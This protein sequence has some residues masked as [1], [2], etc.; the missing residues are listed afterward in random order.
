MASPVQIPDLPS[1]PGAVADS[2]LT[3][4]RSGLTDYKATVGLIRA[5]SLATYANLPG[6][7]QNTDNMLIVRGSSQYR[8]PFSRV[9]FVPGL[10]LWFYNTS[11]QIASSAPGWS[12]VPNTGDA[13][14][15]CAGG[16]TYNTAQAQGGSWTLPSITL[17]I[18]NIPQHQH[19]L[20]AQRQNQGGVPGNSLESLMAGTSTISSIP[21]WIESF[22]TGGVG[23]TRFATNPASPNQRPTFN[24]G[25]ATAP[26]ALGNTW[27]PLAN[28]GNI[29]QKIV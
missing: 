9:G 27:R 5:L 4:V 21:S 3:I 19:Y 16:G 12:I 20:P 1:I 6:G 18:Q 28:V 22:A 15:A 13:L 23:S 24:D 25:T 29:C 26:Y 14:L 7:V 11:A 8:I 17:N 10:A 2:D